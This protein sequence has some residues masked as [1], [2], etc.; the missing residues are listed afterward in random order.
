MHLRWLRYL[1]R[2][3]ASAVLPLRRNLFAFLAVAA[4]LCVGAAV[5][6]RAQQVVPDTLKGDWGTPGQCQAQQSAGAEAMVDDALD[7]PYRFDG[8]WISRWHFYCLVL[9]MDEIGEGRYRARLRCGE[10]AAE[11]LWALDIT[12]EGDSMN[13]SW[14]SLDDDPFAERPWPSGPYQFCQPAQ[15]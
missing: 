9:R 6:A 11:R 1:A 8:Q 14:V 10:D 4:L 15:S 7:A 2:M 12:R 13:M 3:F 5:D